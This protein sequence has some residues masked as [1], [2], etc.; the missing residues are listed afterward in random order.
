LLGVSVI[1]GTSLLVCS[2]VLMSL[3]SAPKN[4]D[5]KYLPNT[6]WSL[7]MRLDICPEVSRLFRFP[8][9][10]NA[11]S[12]VYSISPASHQSTTPSLK[13]LYIPGLELVLYHCKIPLNCLKG[14]VHH[15]CAGPNVWRHSGIWNDA[16][17]LKTNAWGPNSSRVL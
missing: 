11:F 15:P 10:Q 16:W 2:R 5:P 12:M 17:L 8:L 3:C 6:P 14:K 1:W 13:S 7:L 4:V 9:W